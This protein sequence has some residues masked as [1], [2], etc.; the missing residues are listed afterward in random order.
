[1][2]D[3]RERTTRWFGKVSADSGQLQDYGD[4]EVDSYIRSLEDRIADLEALLADIVTLMDNDE[5]TPKER[6]LMKIARAVHT[7]EVSLKPKGE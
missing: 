7:A 6:R 5:R 3:E 1:M 4:P 2:T